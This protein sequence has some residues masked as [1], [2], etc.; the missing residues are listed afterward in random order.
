MGVIMGYTSQGGK[1]KESE[2]VLVAQSS[3]SA[4]QADSL[5]SEPPG[6]LHK[7]VVKIK[8]DNNMGRECYLPYQ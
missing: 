7:V 3:K 6:K 1:V 2:K 5:P 4:S 8:W